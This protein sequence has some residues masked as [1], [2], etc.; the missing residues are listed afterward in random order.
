MDSVAKLGAR[1]QMPLMNKSITKAFSN[2]DQLFAGSLHLADTAVEVL[3]R[4]SRYHYF[5]EYIHVTEVEAFTEEK[6][7]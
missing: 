5:D 4:Q 7:T 6:P 2:F 3:A 1:E